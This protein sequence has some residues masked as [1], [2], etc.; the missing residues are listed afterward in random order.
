M[1][2]VVGTSGIAEALPVTETDLRAVAKNF[3]FMRTNQSHNIKQ[4]V[5][6]NELLSLDDES[7]VAMYLMLMRPKGWVLVSADDV[8]SLSLRIRSR[9]L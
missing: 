8:A 7:A 2:A 5:S 6:G 9:I 3:A 1:M 4:S